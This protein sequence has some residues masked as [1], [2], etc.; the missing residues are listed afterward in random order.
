MNPSNHEL[1]TPGHHTGV[2]HV[3]DPTVA[4]AALSQARRA[5]AEHLLAYAQGLI[6]ASDLIS[7]ACTREGRSLRRITLK[8]FLLARPGVGATR[9]KE[10]LSRFAERLGIDADG[11]GAKPLAWL[12][13]PRS[14]GRRI[15]AWLDV[16]HERRSPV[17]GFPF[18]IPSAPLA[19]A[20]RGAA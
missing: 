10:H 12:I 7:A 19:A 8:Q 18:R 17:A 15:L 11:L 6:S 20:G 16:S 9:T 1:G 4:S 3:V 2:T 13:D 5:R 14:G